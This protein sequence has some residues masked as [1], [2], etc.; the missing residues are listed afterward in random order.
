MQIIY[1]LTIIEGP[2]GEAWVARLSPLLTRLAR[3]AP[4]G[5]VDLGG[6]RYLAWILTQSVRAIVAGLPLVLDGCFE[7]ADGQLYSRWAG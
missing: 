6:E 3:R 5:W 1:H 4:S 2:G 7:A